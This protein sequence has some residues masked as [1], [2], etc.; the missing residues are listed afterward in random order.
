MHS[1]IPSI[2]INKRAGIARPQDLNGKRIGELAVYG[3]DAGIM[4]KGALTD[5]FGFRPET[6][7]WLVGGI[8]FPMKPIDFIPAAHPDGV[9]V[10]TAAEAVDLGGMLERG[11]INALISADVPRCVID[12]SPDVGLLFEDHVAVERDYYRRT[13]IF[14]IMHTVVVP[15]ALAQDEPEL[16][17]AVYR[18]FC[19]AKDAAARELVEGMTFNSMGV[20]VPWLPAL[21]AA[22]RALLGDDW[23]PYG[24]KANVAAV[25]AV[26]RYHHE[27]GI[28]GRRFTPEEIFVPYLLDT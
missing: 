28:T 10:E 2:Y 19:A 11:E 12:G 15:R 3:H 21:I 7:R 26:L 8:D 25:D 18:G 1:A 20:M 6:C 23:W 4:A 9:A 17:T 14:P 16:V 13:G 27:Q 22:D 24:L 5:E